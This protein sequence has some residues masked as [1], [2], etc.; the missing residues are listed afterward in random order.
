MAERGSL[1]HGAPEVLEQ[2][3]TYY[4]GLYSS[5]IPYNEEAT[6]DYVEDIAMKWI[7]DRYRERLMAPLG[8]VE[9]AEALE[10]MSDATLPGR[11]EFCLKWT[12]EQVRYLGIQIHTDPEGVVQDNYG[13]AMHRLAESS[14]FCRIAIEE[15]DSG[16]PVFVPILLLNT[17]FHALRTLMLS[18]GWAGKQLR[19]QWDILTLPYSAGGLNVPNFGTNCMAAQTICIL[20]DTLTCHIFGWSVTA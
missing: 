17:L 12:T 8:P 3:R 10:G 5:Q 14:L 2:F 4:L 7:T 1:V 16:R 15:D 19:L 9:I 6:T 11:L 18:L 20:L 13:K